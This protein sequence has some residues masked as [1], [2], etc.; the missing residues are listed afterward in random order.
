MAADAFSLIASSVR[1]RR[2]FQNTQPMLTRQSENRVKISRL[3]IQMHRQYGLGVWS[4]RSFHPAW[5]EIIGELHWLNRH[6]DGPS[7]AY[8][9]PGGN[10]SI[11]RND[12]FVP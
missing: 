6:R 8:C 4:N 12:D 9:Q 10:E 1:L 5:I 2:I 3:P 7:L 11:G